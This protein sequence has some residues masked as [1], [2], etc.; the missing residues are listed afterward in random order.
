MVN[1]LSRHIGVLCLIQPW[2]RDRS[3]PVPSEV[4]RFY[5]LLQT[6][7]FRPPA[8]TMDLS[9]LACEALGTSS[10]DVGKAWALKAFDDWVGLHAVLRTRLEAHNLPPAM[11]L[12]EKQE[13]C[14]QSVGDIAACAASAL[15]ASVEGPVPE[16]F[17]DIWN[18]MTYV[19]QTLVPGLEARTKMLTVRCKGVLKDFQTLC[20][21]DMAIFEAAVCKEFL[22]ARRLPESCWM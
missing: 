6:H 16:G 14:S 20:S 3:G 21:S 19:M 11:K 9:R 17:K 8:E 5:N 18:Y 10:K 13:N 4:R 7:A 2:D 12:E 15:V 1:V 22:L